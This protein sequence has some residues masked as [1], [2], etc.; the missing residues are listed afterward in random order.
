MR[1][2]LALG[3]HTLG[4]SEHGHA[5][6]DD[7]SM[8]AER[9]PEYRAEIRRLK[10]EYAGRIHVLLGY[11]H[12]WLSPANVSEYDYWI[13]SVHYVPKDGQL[14]CVDNT[15]EAGGR[16]PDALRR[17]P[18]RPVP[19]L[20]PHGL[21]VHRGHRR[22]HT[23]PHRAGDEVQRGPGPVRRRRPPLPGARAGMRGAG[24]PQRQADR[25][26]HRGHRPGLSHPA[27][28]R[29]G[30]AARGSASAAGG[31]SSPAT[32][33]IRIIWTSASRRRWRWPGTAASKPPGNT[34]AASR[35]RYPL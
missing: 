27:L 8:P 9:E 18:L 6:Y 30:H 2:A 10:E 13:E 1:A 28:P 32:A 31:S 23:G 20:L 4:F 35:W 21:P 3:F 16:H 26:Q 14:W 19:G 24:R 5:D 25:D 17:R 12:D 29:A 33:T 15:R 11:E 22:G 7:C 34:G